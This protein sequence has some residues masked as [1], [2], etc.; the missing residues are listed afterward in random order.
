MHVRER[1][2]ERERERLRRER[3]RGRDRQTDRKT[4][5]QGKRKR[6][7]RVPGQNGVSLLCI[8][9]EIHHSG[10]KP[11]NYD[12]GKICPYLDSNLCVMS[13]L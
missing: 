8:M 10:L 2:R 9:L 13:K 12:T 5:K 6:I 1:E 3:E 4:G 11:S 7:S